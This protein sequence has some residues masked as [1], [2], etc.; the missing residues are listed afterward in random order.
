[1]MT[2]EQQIQRKL[3]VEKMKILR[4]D[5]EF[6]VIRGYTLISGTGDN[7]TVYLCKEGKIVQQKTTCNNDNRAYS[8]ST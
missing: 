3:L 1:M 8:H 5:N 4:K 2:K 6:A 7:K